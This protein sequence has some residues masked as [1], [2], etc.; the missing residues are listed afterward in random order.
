MRTAEMTTL[1]SI[2]GVMRMDRVRNEEVKEQCGIMDIVRFCRKRRRE[3]CEHV[4][5]AEENQLIKV[6]KNQKP[7]GKRPGRLQRE[8]LAS[9]ID[10][11]NA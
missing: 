6:A 5:K 7:T 11:P 4:E 9:S 1:R 2:I 10:S 8:S 3:W